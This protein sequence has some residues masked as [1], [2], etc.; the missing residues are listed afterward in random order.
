MTWLIKWLLQAGSIALWAN[1]LPGV[2]LKNFTSALIVVVVLGI[3]NAVVKPI[4]T[5]LTLPLT[6]LT[7]GIFLIVINVLM[8]FLADWLI[9]GL[10]IHGFVNALLF[11]FL[12]GIT[13]TAI[14]RVLEKKA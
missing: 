3:L 14:D 4:L 9:P 2:E 10:Q 13:N 12:V 1:L 7:L 6:I 11:G 8:I 5:L